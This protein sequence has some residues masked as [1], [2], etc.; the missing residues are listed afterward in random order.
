[1]LLFDDNSIYDKH[2]FTRLDYSFDIEGLED[3]KI[4]INNAVTAK[5]RKIKLDAV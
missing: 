3:E 2:T 4:V 5:Y 1:M